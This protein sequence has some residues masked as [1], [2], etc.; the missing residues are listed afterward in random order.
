MIVVRAIYSLPIT[1]YQANLLAIICFLENLTCLQ[2][3]QTNGLMAAAM[4]FV[5]IGLESGKNSKAAINAISSIM[6]KIFGAFVLCQYIFYRLKIRNIVINTTVLLFFVLLPGFFIGFDGLKLQYL[7]WLD[8][9]S[10]DLKDEV[11]MSLMHIIQ[12]F[13]SQSVNFS[14]IQL[15]GISFSL[16]PL[17]NVKAYKSFDF[18]FLYLALLL[19]ASVSLNHKAESPT[20]IIAIVGIGIWYIFSRLHQG[21]KLCFLFFSL[22]LTSL[23]PS[24]LFPAFIRSEYITPYALK[25][26]PSALTWLMLTVELTFYKISSAQ[27]KTNPSPICAGFDQVNHY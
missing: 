5:F 12:A 8:M 2:N 1:L 16:I 25:G 27:L 6:I 3:F 20:F 4:L 26:L 11:G 21:F 15:L 22:I 24:S 10:V 18:R 14:Y 17:I 9:L 19:I 23:S 13:S 7:N